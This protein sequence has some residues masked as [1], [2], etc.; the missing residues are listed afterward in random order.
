MPTTAIVIAV[1]VALALLVLFLRGGGPRRVGMGGP[2]SAPHLPARDEIAPAADLPGEIRDAVERELAAGRKI[3]AIKLVR[4]NS[5]LGLKEAK[6]FVE[7][8]PR[9]D[10]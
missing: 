3:E 6:E 8:L 7:R 4:E 2:G 10:R 5:G 9:G 1:I